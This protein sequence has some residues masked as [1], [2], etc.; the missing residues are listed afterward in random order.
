MS[1]PVV[2]LIGPPGAGKTVVGQELATRLG[3]S[4]HD[5]DAAVEAGQGRAISDIFVQDGEDAF[6]AL[7]RAEVLR[8]LADEAGVVSLGGGAVMQDE[9]FRALREG[10]HRVVFLDVTIAD[11]SRRVGFDASRPLLVVNPRAS[12]TRLMNARRPTYEE[13]ATIRVDT[14]G[15]TPAEI[16]DEVVDRLAL[17]GDA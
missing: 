6:R 14:G 10:G 8:A 15:R 16:A 7:E 5:T 17:A 2:V 1:R 12:W 4:V 3:T 11:A 9:V 13:L